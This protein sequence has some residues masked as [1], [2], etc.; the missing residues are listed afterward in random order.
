MKKSII[1]S[2][3]LMV[4][5]LFVISP[6]L[7]SDGTQ[8]PDPSS[9]AVVN[10]DAYE[11]AQKDS[12]ETAKESGAQTINPSTTAQQAVPAT[13]T[14]EEELKRD[15][16]PR[17]G[18]SDFLFT[19]KYLTFLIFMIVGIV[20]LYGKR[21][22]RWVRM[23]ILASAFVIFGLDYIFPLHPSPVCGITKLFMFK[24]TTGKFSPV[25]IALL[26]AMLVPS[27]IG[28]KI[29]C[30][31]VC[32]L[33]A[34]QEL[35]NKI[36]FK[37]RF[38]RFNFTVF[39][40]IRMS[41]LVM[42]VF[43]FFKVKNHLALLG[44]KVGTEGAEQTWTS[45]SA[46]DFYEPINFFEL[47]HWHVDTLFIIMFVVLV[48]VS[49]IL[50]RPFC[51]AI[52]PVGAITWI[53]EKVAPGRV[54]VDHSK[55]IECGSCQEAAPCPTIYHLVEGKSKAIPDCTSCGECLGYCEEERA[56]KFGFKR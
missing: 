5:I 19:G 46:Y 33:G 10:S 20:L 18:L 39:N 28:R 30:G 13:E 29:F 38:K 2:I 12:L 36:P 50:Y 49:L 26:I 32:P 24:F 21:V 55:C 34:L 17:R 15:R 51:Y 45:Y 48:I 31:W 11:Q 54:R 16:R 52:C 47:L 9:E 43:T 44:E 1:V 25:F 41:L 42:F 22:N 3:T 27:L 35:I 4:S 56:I 7:S 37:P 40:A 14:A 6:A 23:I 53:L 8:K